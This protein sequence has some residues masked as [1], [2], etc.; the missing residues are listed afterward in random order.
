MNIFLKSTTVALLAI[1]FAANATE[2]TNT[3]ITSTGVKVVVDLDSNLK[4]G[5]KVK[6]DY[7]KGLKTMRC[8][9]KSCSITFTATAALPKNATKL[10]YKIGIY[11]GN[12]LLNST[13]KN[14]TVN[15][16]LSEVSAAVDNNT[17]QTT[18]VETVSTPYS[19][20]AND[21]SLL[22]DSAQLG[23]KPTDWA[24]TKD[25][26]TGLI[27][28]VKTDDGGLRDKNNRYT[29][30]DAIYPGNPSKLGAAT[31]TDGFVKAV[32]A[33]GLCGSSNWRLPTRTELIS[34][35]Y[36]SDGKYKT[37]GADEYGDVCSGSPTY[38]TINTTFFPDSTRWYWSSTPH[39]SFSGSAW[40][41]D[42]DSIVDFDGYGKAGN[43]N[44]RLVR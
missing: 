38:P 23:S 22:P 42:I 20:I 5:E 39:A 30:Y 10:D 28:E 35:I 18:S 7:G 17:S 43:G 33:Q 16:S 32:N 9:N 6:I 37:L 44:V 2:I 24:C 26:K 1:P 8:K 11:N 34:L 21:G 12:T 3:E 13:L 41:V 40:V 29:N 14:G 15:F 36:C 4:K 31:N 19:K 25:N 27:W